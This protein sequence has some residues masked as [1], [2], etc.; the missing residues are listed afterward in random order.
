MK[1]PSTSWPLALAAAAAC[2]LCC[3]DA[4]AQFKGPEEATDYRQAVLTVM[5]AHFG[6]IGAMVNGKVA[7]DAN[8][9]QVNADLVAT[10]A[11]LPWTAFVE[12]SDDG[13][14]NARPEVWS[15]PEKF[16][17]ASQRLQDA[18]AKLAE[19]ARSGQQ[20][21]VKAA[22]DRTSEACKACHDDFRKQH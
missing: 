8:A 18:A 12:G 5:S 22:F 3:G 14:T 16:R 10:L 4:L 17:A 7:F 13:D 15:Q 11:R 1:R 19:A 6:R 20:D 21:A 2:L 9:A